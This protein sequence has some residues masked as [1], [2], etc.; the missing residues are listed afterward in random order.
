M[1]WGFY[2]VCAGPFRCPLSPSLSERLLLPRNARIPAHLRQLS[3]RDREG[4]PGVHVLSTERNQQPIGAS[5]RK[6]PPVALA[7]VPAGRTRPR[8]AL[9]VHALTDEKNV[10]GGVGYGEGDRSGE[11]G[12]VGVGVD[13]D[14]DGAPSVGAGEM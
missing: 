14:A 3:R 1:D 8:F 7:R 12:R 9:D 11:L 10:V 4:D 13:V 2:W 6:S 5:C